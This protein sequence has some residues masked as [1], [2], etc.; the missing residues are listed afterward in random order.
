MWKACWA[1]AA[2]TKLRGRVSSGM[3]T[4]GTESKTSLEAAMFMQDKAG[5]LKDRLPRSF[6]LI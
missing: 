2:S 1:G 6:S 3:T 5:F 4:A